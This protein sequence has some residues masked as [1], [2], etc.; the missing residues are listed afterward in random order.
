[1][2]YTIALF[3]AI[4]LIS[5]NSNTADESNTSATS[6]QIE[7]L[8][9]NDG[10][11]WIANVET[12]EGMQAM[13]QRVSSFTPSGVESYEALGN[14]LSA[15]ANQIVQQCDMEGEPHAQLHLVLA[16]MLEEIGNLKSTQQEEDGMEALLRFEALLEA[17]FA[18]FEAAG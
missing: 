5:C 6:L 1:M 11:K 7:G 3:I 15:M 9:L 18:H 14:D 8:H 13:K 16:P 17:Y 4:V 12:E 2:K 10:Q